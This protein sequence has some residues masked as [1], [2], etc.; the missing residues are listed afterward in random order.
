MQYLLLIF[1]FYFLSLLVEKDGYFSPHHN[2]Y[3]VKHLRNH[4]FYYTM[5]FNMS[6]L[7]NLYHKYIDF[8]FLI[9]IKM[10]KLTTILN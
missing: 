4:A 10:T 5:K 3:W 1:Q 9:Y 8:N 7:V 6:I 2:I